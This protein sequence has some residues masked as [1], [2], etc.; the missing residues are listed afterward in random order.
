MNANAQRAAR[1]NAKAAD[2]VA[3]E[4][5]R[6]IE[7]HERELAVH[8]AAIATLAKAKVHADVVAELHTAAAGQKEAPE[9]AESYR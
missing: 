2:L 7:W 3:A 8:A 9:D 4:L 1:D 5:Q 6:L